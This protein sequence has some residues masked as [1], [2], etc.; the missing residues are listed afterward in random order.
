MLFAMVIWT[1]AG[2]IPAQGADA[3]V[4][5]HLRTEYLESPMGIDATKPR[6][7]WWIP[8]ERRGVHQSAYRVL[9]ASSP[10]LL[11]KEQGDCWDS[12]KVDSEQQIQV[13]YRGATL[14]SNTAYWWKVRVWLDGGEVS[15]WSTP[16]TWSMGLLQPNDWGAQWITY[17]GDDITVRQPATAFRKEMTINAPVKRATAYVTALGVYELRINGEPVGDHI[18]SPEW[19]DYNVRV[20]YHAYDITKNLKQGSNAIAALVGDGWYAGRIGLANIVPNGPTWGI[21]GKRVKL[22]AQV[23]IECTDGSRRRIITDDSWRCSQ[24]GFIRQNDILDGEIHDARKEAPGWDGAGFNDAEWRPATSSELGSKPLLVAQPNEPI[25]VVQEL[26]PV[27]MTE[28]QTGTYIYDLGQNMVGRCR[29][30]GEAAPGVTAHF[31]YGEALNPDGTLYTKNL[32]GA[33]QSDS[34][35]FRGG[36]RETFEPRFTYHGFRYVEITGLAAKPAPD[37]LTGRVFNSSCPDAGKFECSSDLLNKLAHNIWWTQR[38][39][40]MST[41]TDCPQRDERLGWMGDIQVFSQTAVFN[42]DMAGFFTKW[43][44]DVRD[45]QAADGRF[46]DFAPHPFDFNARFSGVPA[47]GD[48][49][50]VVPWRA[51]ENYADTRLLEE[52]YAAA[53]RWV[54][55]I[56]ANNPD[57]IWNKGRNND[58]NDWLNADTLKLDNWPKTGGEVPKEV[59]ATAFFAYSTELVGRMATAIGATN[60]AAKYGKLASEIRAA[61]CKAFVSSDGRIKGDTQAGYALALNFD[62]LPVNLREKAVGY[63]LAGLVKYNGHISTGIQSTS[64][65][66]LELTRW[67]HNDVAYKLINNRSMPSWGYSID[68]GATTIWERWDGYVEGRGF[69]DPGMNSLNHWAIGSVG[70]WMYRVILG[71]SPDAPGWK[72]F[73]V[74]PQP[75]GGVTW[76]KGHYDSI[77]GTIIVDW[78][79]E[80]DLFTLSTTIPANT[81][82]WVYVPMAT[83]DTIR[84]NGKPVLE[85]EGVKAAGMEQ[86][87]VKLHVL[88]GTYTF[89]S[90]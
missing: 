7:S 22:L 36:S 51:Y 38:A 16:A 39:N 85:A 6:L 21:Y 54:E 73:S 83:L 45:D 77:Y 63:M 4:P 40:L 44:R 75:G 86:G 1:V 5:E 74:R 12:G 8:G 59:L 34:Y 78:K 29:F 88:S 89:R 3:M 37:A 26:T 70:E 90:K 28:P 52:H 9:V 47:W 32:R 67:D 79:I 84:E 80:G 57:L 42:M 43:L 23:E 35:T 58:Y 87:A 49:G 53:K 19:T 61:F 2:T 33:A 76:A 14:M 64:R 15:N 60:D 17:P 50:V 65:M 20:Q 68:Q 62:I 31:R 56:H 25:R 13:V 46:P 66:M 72:R 24:D 81:S 30:T 48:A 27:R 18:L 55:Y 82:A 41:P 71:L 10:E 11:A 69:Q